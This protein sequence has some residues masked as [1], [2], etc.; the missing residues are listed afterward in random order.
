MGNHGFFN[1]LEKK[2]L[3]H[4]P[5]FLLSCILSLP[6]CFNMPSS[7]CEFDSITSFCNCLFVASSSPSYQASSFVVKSRTPQ[8]TSFDRGG[9]DTEGEAQSHS[10]PKVSLSLCSSNM[11]RDTTEEL[12]PQGG[13]ALAHEVTVSGAPV[14]VPF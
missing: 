7:P 9:R 2:R 6:F 8:K 12:N 14:L 13:H 4:F 10:E 11:V 5:S 1:G 3:L